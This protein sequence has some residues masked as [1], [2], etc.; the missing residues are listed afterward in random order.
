[1]RKELQTPQKLEKEI[2]ARA[3]AEGNWEKDDKVVLETASACVHDASEGVRHW[4]SQA[5]G[6]VGAPAVPGILELLMSDDP[7]LKS[8]ATQALTLF[9]DPEGKKELMKVRASKSGWMASQKDLEVARAI[10]KALINM[11]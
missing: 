8:S 6:K 2:A 7:K 5:L 1:M 11:Q 9:S 4:C 3:F 10:D